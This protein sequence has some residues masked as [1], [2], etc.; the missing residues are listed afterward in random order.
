MRYSRKH[1]DIYT[2]PMQD[3]LREQGIGVGQSR[4]VRTQAAGLAPGAG[5]EPARQEILDF[6]VSKAGHVPGLCFT[7]FAAFRVAAARTSLSTADQPV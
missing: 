4:A 2:R 5:C 1:L 7:F 3:M 6:M